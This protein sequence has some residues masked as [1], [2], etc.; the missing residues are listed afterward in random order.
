MLCAITLGRPEAARVAW[1][2]INGQVTTAA[3]GRTYKER[4]K[5]EAARVRDDVADAAPVI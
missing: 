3:K 1:D 4:L 2:R 5:A